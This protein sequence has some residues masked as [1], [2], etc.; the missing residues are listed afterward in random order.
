MPNPNEVTFLL[1][2]LV[3]RVALGRMNSREGRDAHMTKPEL[4]ALDD[5]KE[6]GVDLLTDF[7]ARHGVKVV[8]KLIGSGHIQVLESPV[9]EV[10]ALA[11]TG[12]RHFGYAYRWY[13]PIASA[14][15]D[16]L[17]MRLTVQTMQ[18]RGYAQATS[19]SRTMAR[20]VSPSGTPTYLMVKYR[21]PLSSAITKTLQKLLE[22]GIEDNA[23][24]FVFREQPHRL[25]AVFQ[26]THHRIVVEAPPWSGAL[27]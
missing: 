11:P 24:I 15:M 16:Q 27:P 12:Y 18:A 17:A 7:E 23:E 10:A 21:M 25:K 26:R 3:R 22:D 5:L 13:K 14:M 6:W 9:G 4:A 2:D 8:Q 19:R 20:V 1:Y